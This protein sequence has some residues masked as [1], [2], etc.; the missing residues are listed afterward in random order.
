VSVAPVLDDLARTLAQEMPRRR[1]LRL[2][3]AS[4]VAAMVPGGRSHLARAASSGTCA[5]DQRVCPILVNLAPADW[6]CPGGSPARRYKCDGDYYNP[7]CSDTCGGPD[8]LPCTSRKKDEDGFSYFI[9]CS[10]KYHSGCEN[11]EC[12]RKKVCGPDITDALGDALSRVKSEFA[13]W[14]SS[15][16]GEACSNLVTIPWATFSWDISQLSPEGRK[17][18]TKAFGPECASCGYTVQV[19]GACHFDGSVNYVAYGTMMRLCRDHY[20]ADGSDWARWF[21]EDMM[22]LLIAAHK[23]F[24][25]VVSANVGSSAEWASAGYRGWPQKG[26]APAGDR[27]NCTATC[28]KTY[29][30][31]GLTVQWY[32][33]VIRPSQ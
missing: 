33:H 22:I 29:S 9:C 23:S 13:G 26:S 15:D 8:D 32:P 14:S 30:G 17:K 12:V 2:L 1:A 28:S 19:G 27:P 6:C 16:R 3:G 31:P 25:G 10:K 7:H 4:A 21:S 5:P 18:F 11:G 20:N 24:T